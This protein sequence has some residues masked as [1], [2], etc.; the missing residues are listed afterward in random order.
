MKAW[1]REHFGDT[2]KKYKKIEEDLNKLE[3]KTIDRQLSPQE[4]LSRKQ[5]QEDLWVVAQSRVPI[6]IEGKI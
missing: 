4:M 3:E 2:F 1:N 6:K 5:L